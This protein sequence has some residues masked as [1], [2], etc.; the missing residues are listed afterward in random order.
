MTWTVGHT[1]TCIV[2]YPYEEMCCRMHCSRAFP[3]TGTVDCLVSCLLSQ[4]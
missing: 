1:A 3:L 2:A 4:V